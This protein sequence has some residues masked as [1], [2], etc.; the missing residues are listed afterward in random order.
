MTD[1]EEKYLVQL[2][3]IL[4]QSGH[5]LDKDKVLMFMNLVAPTEGSHSQKA[6]TGFFKRNPELK[7]KGSSGTDPL[8]ASQANEH[9]RDTFF[10]ELDAFTGILNA[11][12]KIKW[13]SF[14]DI[15]SKFIYNMDKLASDTTKWR[16]KIATD[17][18]SS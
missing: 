8:H 4:G 9:V 5:G 7:L 14:G 12:G 2:C 6:V 11:L 16:H 3:K 13:K 1:N 17:S 10:C 15:P 18:E